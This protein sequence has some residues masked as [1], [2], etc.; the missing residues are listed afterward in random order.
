MPEK[1]I[2]TN[3]SGEKIGERTE[4]LIPARTSTK[5]LVG[6]TLLAQV[7]VQLVGLLP[8]PDLVHALTTPEMIS[9]VSV[10]L[11]AL[12]ARFT[13]SPSVSKFL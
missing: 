8:Y 1:V 7:Y 6:G 4:P 5:S 9:L 12:V 10:G 3:E 13:K 11:T 2:L